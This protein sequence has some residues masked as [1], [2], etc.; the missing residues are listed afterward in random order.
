MWCREDTVTLRKFR[1]Y[2]TGAFSG[3]DAHRMIRLAY[4][5]TY[6]LCILKFIEG[7]HKCATL[8][9]R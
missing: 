7:G 6:L 2:R 4:Y 1:S 5:E 8:Q 9:D 3:A